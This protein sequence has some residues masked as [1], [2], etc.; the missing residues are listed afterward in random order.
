MH[1]VKYFPAIMLLSIL[2]LLSACGGGGGGSPT[3]PLSDNAYLSGIQLSV[4]KMDQDYYSA[5]LAYTGSVGYLASSIQITA[6]SDDAN[7]T[8]TIDGLATAS[9]AASN[10]IEL[11][12]GS[13]NITILVTAQDGISTES[14]SLDITRE[15]AQSFAQRAYIK[16]SNTGDSDAFGRSVALSGNTLAVGADFEDSS[17]VGVNGGAEAD[18]SLGNAGAVYVFTRTNGDWSQQAYIKASNTGGADQFGWSVALSGDTLA[19]AALF[20]GSNGVAETDN[21]ATESGAVYV[22]R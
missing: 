20:E 13:N 10:L 1:Y 18:D 3:V 12:E 16:A 19:V 21:S 9:G 15:V 7:A 17:G 2:T 8:L 22:L 5:Q 6:D 4:G 14:Y 11:A